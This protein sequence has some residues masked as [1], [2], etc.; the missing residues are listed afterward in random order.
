MLA[1]E[2][3]AK[4]PACRGTGLGGP[5][6]RCSSLGRIRFQGNEEQWILCGYCRGTGTVDCPRCR[7]EGRIRFFSFQCPRCG[8]VGPES[9]GHLDELYA[10]LCPKCGSY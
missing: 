10:D 3:L 7:R 5:C 2:R 1:R 8:F 6:A 9:E 4:C